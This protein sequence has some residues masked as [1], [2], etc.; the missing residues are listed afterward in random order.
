MKQ[1][2]VISAALIFA[3]VILAEG[4]ASQNQTSTM[5]ISASEI[6]ETTA[7]EETTTAAA[8]EKQTTIETTPEI[9]PESS[10]EEFINA[11]LGDGEVIL[12]KT[13]EES[14]LY[15]KIV[16]NDHCM[17]TYIELPD[18]APEIL[19]PVMAQSIVDFT[20]DPENTP[21]QHSYSSTTTKKQS[22][23]QLSTIIPVN[24]KQLFL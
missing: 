17:N 7:P 22:Q 9:T 2:K 10:K 12:E 14:G 16:R 21:Q 8:S 20:H 23:R 1:I 24:G 13:D 19:C 11:L 15:M 4:C 6:T 18:Y 5:T 3:A